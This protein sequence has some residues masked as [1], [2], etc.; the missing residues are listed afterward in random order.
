MALAAEQHVFH[1]SVAA[2]GQYVGMLEQEQLVADFAGLAAG[3]QL[4]LQLPSRT[5]GHA[6]D[7]AQFEFPHGMGR[8]RHVWRSVI[9]H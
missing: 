7:V 6:A 2:Q 1:A 3:F 9:R 5:V 4:L 8:R